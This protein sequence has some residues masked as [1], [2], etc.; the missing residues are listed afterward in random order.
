M[1]GWSQK[2]CPGCGRPG[3]P[4]NDVCTAC[5]DALESARQ[6][7]DLLVTRYPAY[8][9][10]RLPCRGTGF[11]S[12]GLPYTLDR[13]V[14]DALAAALTALAD[15]PELL[16]V[17][18]PPAS[19]NTQN[20]VPAD[21]WYEALSVPLTPE[22]AAAVQALVPALQN[23]VR[24]AYHLGLER[25]QALLVQLAAGDVTMARFEAAVT[26]KPLHP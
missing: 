26:P 17:S 9:T 16:G 20:L 23:A 7:Q 25:G 15:R 24:E 19:G 12:L 1:K 6:R 18:Y 5:H 21:R 14:Q 8:R 10:Y 2:P 11:P 4:L 13:A 22:Q 3:H